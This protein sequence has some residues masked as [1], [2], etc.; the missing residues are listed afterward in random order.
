[1]RSAWI[2]VV[3]VTAAACGGRSQLGGT[4]GDAA[5]VSPPEPSAGG[6]VHRDCAP[7]DGAAYTFALGG[8]V[9][10]TCSS[11]NVIP[12]SVHITIWSP[13]P[14]GPGTYPIGDG[15]FASG[16]TAIVCPTGPG[17]CTT[18]SHGTLVLSAFAPSPS[19][20]IAG[21]YTLV[22]PD[23]TVVSTSFSDVVFCNDSPMCG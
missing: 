14:S 22:M 20:T 2:G 18:A 5:A 7:N 16:S 23:G 3:L 13:L 21:T 1:M 6:A 11:T 8:P 17:P 15:T 19:S 4:L 9:A 12:G 10:P